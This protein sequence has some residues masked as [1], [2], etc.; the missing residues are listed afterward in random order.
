MGLEAFRDRYQEPYSLL[1]KTIPR[2]PEEHKA[3]LSSMDHAGGPQE[4]C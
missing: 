1:S 2:D 3:E 4:Q